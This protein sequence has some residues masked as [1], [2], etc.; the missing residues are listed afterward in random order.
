MQNKGLQILFHIFGCE[1][2]LVSGIAE[3]CCYSVTFSLYPTLFNGEK[4]S[5]AQAHT[6][7]VWAFILRQEQA[8]LQKFTDFP[9]AQM[10]SRRCALSFF[11]D[12]KY[13]REGNK[14]KGQ[15]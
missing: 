8:F 1:G 12:I 10:R 15:K 11:G 13:E 2:Y 14:S 6:G 3:S 7:P 5:I 4:E 9:A